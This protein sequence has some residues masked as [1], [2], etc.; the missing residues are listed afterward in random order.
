MTMSNNPIAINRE[1]IHVWIIDLAE[2]E[3]LSKQRLET[4]SKTEQDRASRFRFNTHRIRYINRWFAYRHI[5]AQYTDTKAENITIE[6]DSK[7]KPHLIGF[8]LEFN[9][10]SSADTAII[11][12]A[13]TA[14]GADIEKHREDIFETDCRKLGFLSPSETSQYVSLPENIHAI[15]FLALWTLKEAYLKA[16]GRGL[17]IDPKEIS[18]DLVDGSLTGSPVKQDIGTWAFHLFSLVD[19][20]NVAIATKT[21]I[22]EIKLDFW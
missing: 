5:L 3:N 2:K 6:R 17:T 10:S 12:L 16:L 8:P 1:S 4:L 11:A 14:V 15:S 19:N 21:P 9:T 7:G 22:K 13:K 20:H 18:F